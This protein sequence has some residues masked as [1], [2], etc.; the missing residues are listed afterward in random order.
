MKLV[1]EAWIAKLAKSMVLKV[2]VIEASRP[3]SGYGVDSLLAAELRSWIQ[4]E[5]QAEIGVFELL[6]TEATTPLARR[7]VE[8][9]KAVPG[10]VKG[11][12]A[13]GG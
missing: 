8:V 10:G 13:S 9:S 5:E 1:T 3:M 6:G 11:V 12:D 7:T 4:Y 2:E